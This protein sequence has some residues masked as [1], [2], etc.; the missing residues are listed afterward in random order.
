MFG[1]VLG[2]Y[3]IIGKIGS[4]GM[5][6]VYRAR[7]DQL[8][9]DVALKVLPTGA[10]IDEATRKRFRQEALIL[11]KLNHPNIAIIHEFGSQGRVDF[12]V[13]E[14]ISG[15]SLKEILS[16]GPLPERQIQRL[17]LQ[18]ADAL[19]V[20]HQHNI[21]HSDLKPANI[22]VTSD[23]RIKVLDF[24]LAKL[25]QEASLDAAQSSTKGDA[26]PGTLP[27]MAPE[28]VK[29]ESVDARTDVYAAGAVLY[30]MTTGQRPFLETSSA[31]LMN[32]ILHKAP[33]PPRELNQQLSSGMQAIVLKALEK[34]PADRQHSIQELRA[35]LQG[36]SPRALPRSGAPEDSEATPLEIGHVLFVDLVRYS[37][38]PMEEQRLQ[39]R[40][41]HRIAR[42]TKE[43]ARA[44]SADQ[45]ISLQS[46]DGMALV[47]FEDPEAP[48]RCAV[49]V[50]R[51][52]SVKPEIELRMGVHSGPVYR[53]SDINAARA[54]AGGGIN[55]AQ[56]VMD[57]GQAGHILVSQAVVDV[58]GQLS[59]WSS[60]FHD[61]GNIEVKHGTHVHLFNFYMEGVGN[62]KPPSKSKKAKISRK[63]NILDAK[64]HKTARSGAGSLRREKREPQTLVTPPAPQSSARTHTLNITV[65]E[66][67]RWA[68]LSL[69]GCILVLGA[70]SLS[71][72]VVRDSVFHIFWHP[73]S[74]PAGIPSL[75]EGMHVVV[76][77]FD[78]QSG[79]TL[80][81]VAE[82]LGEELSRKLSAL[83][84]LHV[85]SASAAKEQAKRQK[86][87]LKG[88]AESIGRNFGINLIVHGTV[89]QGG[90]WTR[91]NVD[92]DD[93]AAARRR[94]TKAFSY[95]AAS[96]NLLDLQNQVYKSIVK[97]LRLRPNHQEQS[98]AANPTSNNDAYDHY[99]QGRFAFGRTAIGFYQRAI[100]EDPQFALA[101]VG[102]SNAY[103][104]IYRDTEEPSWVQK[105][106]ERAQQAKKLN[107]DLPEVHLALG[108]TYRRVGKITEAIAEFDRVKKL[109]PNS[110]LP[111]LRLGRTYEDAGQRD[112]AIDAYTK[113]TLL[114]PY[115]LI[116]RN[117][118]G[119]AYLGIGE[120]EKALAQFRNVINLDPTNYFGYMNTGAAHLSQGEFEKSIPE[121][122]KALQ[123]APDGAHDDAS[124]HSDL[125]TAYFYTK[126]FADSVRENE[127]AVAISP[128]DYSLVG[129]LAGSYRWSKKKKK[130]AETYETAIALAT[131]QLEVNPKDADAL[132]YLALYCANNG[133]FLRAE[134]YIRSAR[135][136]DPSN[137]NLIVNEAAVRILANQPSPALESL[138]LAL[139]KGYSAKLLRADPEF[140]SLQ[141]HPEFQRLMQKYL[142]N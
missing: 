123:L 82:G 87:D 22:M 20:A 126:R 88:S 136:T 129:N 98:Q 60:A 43:F 54:V 72:P 125:G 97:E 80:G 49:E 86:V 70:M 121:F 34:V 57:C 79:E 81:Y 74:P 124:I 50:S 24:G 40:E 92:F 90:G 91:I 66:V 142:Q 36:L 115:S 56:R 28:Q 105:A 58:L 133:N 37:V 95:P 83:P 46:G 39:L 73:I 140:S 35:E 2:H 12:L 11:A 99:L 23:G 59:H 116:D 131:K 96:I 117:E 33:R 26:G 5:G 42:S 75:E 114:A 134:D 113:A 65:P 139:E 64:Q 127:I 44:S 47:F 89:Q 15:K 31:Q 3:R 25:V 94:L 14:L 53:V 38:L 71:I 62:A 9:R 7:D 101:Y 120:Y 48:V 63:Q 138:R 107:D 122:E 30:E 13:M 118:L 19:A 132:G 108:D 55:L 45:L 141:N 112:K 104:A 10:L 41:L 1:E 6:E 17:G 130:A 8:D 85:V 135:L 16:Q 69:V 61:L 109:S 106:L 76:L 137:S 21:V 68:W 111:W 128:H 32:A 119:A 102:L 78:V 77:P 4:G 52:V 27:Y 100:E 110:D 18:L 103:L 67:P 84:S 29:G 51:A 93:V